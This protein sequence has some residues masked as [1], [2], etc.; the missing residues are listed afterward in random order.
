MGLLF[1]NPVGLAAG[2]DKDGDHIDALGA[3]GFGFIEVG[4]TTPRPQPG[5]P[6]PRVFRAAKAQALINRLGFNNKG[7]DHLVRQAQRAR[8][9]GVLGI[10]IGKNADTPIERAL[11]DYLH[12]L[13]KVHHLADYVTINVSSPNTEGLRDLQSPDALSALLGALKERNARLSAAD[14]RRVPLVV[15]VAPDLFPEDIEAISRV[16]LDVAIDGLIATNTT[17][18]RPEG[19]TLPDEHGGLS[20]RPLFGLSTAVLRT[21]H[22]HLGGRI[23]IIGTGGI[24]SGQDAIGKIE[25]GASLVQFYT[26]LIYRGPELVSECAGAIARH[27]RD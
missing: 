26:G 11:D 15:K 7:V 14:G 19:V 27:H 6:Q 2:M 23:P 17:V 1:P 18:D 20:G 3:L 4:T 10:N 5:N 16:L 12:C 25:E 13:N 24:L 9:R 22:K 8:Y 21:F